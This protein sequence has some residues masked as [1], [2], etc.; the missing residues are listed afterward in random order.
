MI[1]AKEITASRPYETLQ[2]WIGEKIRHFQSTLQYQHRNV[3]KYYD[4]VDRLVPRALVTLVQRNRK[5]KFR[6]TKVTR[7]LGTRLLTRWN[8]NRCYSLRT[9]FFISEAFFAKLAV[10]LKFSM[11][12]LNKI[13]APYKLL[14]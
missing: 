2:G 11:A 7:A 10:V 4:S 13:F 3:E 9:T 14:N 12:H 5:T 1:T 8:A 6:W